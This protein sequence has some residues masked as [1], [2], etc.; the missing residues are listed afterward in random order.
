MST[1]ENLQAE[2][3]RLQKAFEDA[4]KFASTSCERCPYDNKLECR[5]PENLKKITCEA[6]VALYFQDSKN[7]RV[8]IV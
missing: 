4:V 1:V 8:K 6:A 5:R 3:K 7:M 2:N